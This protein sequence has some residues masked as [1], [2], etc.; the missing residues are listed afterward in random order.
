[1]SLLISDQRMG[2]AATATPLLTL[3]A[4]LLVYGYRRYFQGELLCYC[5]PYAAGRDEPV[6][7]ADYFRH[8]ISPA[9]PQMPPCRPRLPF[10][11]VTPACRR[12]DV[13]A[14]LLRFTRALRRYAR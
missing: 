11:D 12:V 5:A 2:A 9:L 1:M 3:C 10:S 4:V 6:L 14:L 8:A 7:H 13:A